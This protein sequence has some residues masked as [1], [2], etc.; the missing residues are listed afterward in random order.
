LIFL[1]IGLICGIS[2]AAPLNLSIVIEND[3]NYTNSIDVDLALS[4]DNTTGSTNCSFSN[5]GTSWP[6]LE[7]YS[8]S[9]VYTLPAGNGDRYVY[10]RCTNDGEN[11]SDTVHAFIILD[12]SAPSIDSLSPANNGVSTDTT[13]VISAILSDSGSGIDSSLTE[14]KVDGSNV[15]AT[16]DS[17]SGKVSYTSPSELSEANHSVEITAYDKV[18]NFTIGSWSFIVD[19]A[20]V[21]ENFYP[22]N[23]DNVKSTSFTVS[24]DISDSGSGINTSR[25]IMKIND[26]TVN[27][28]FPSGKI[29][30]DADFSEGTKEIELWIYDLSGSS[31]Y[32]NWNITIDKSEPT[33]TQMDPADKST[34]SFVNRISARL[35]D[36][37]S[38]I[39]ESSI[40]MKL[41]K[42]DVTSFTSYSGSTLTYSTISGLGGG[43]HEV[44]IWVEDKAGNSVFK[45]WEFTISSK[46]PTID[47]ISPSEGSSTSNKKPVISARFTDQS[48]SGLNLNSPKIYLDGVDYTS[49]AK[50]DNSKRIISYTTTADLTEGEHTAK[51]E[52][53]DNAFA[54]AERSWTFTIDTT[55]PAAPTDLNVSVVG[56]RATLKWTKA[57]DAAKYNIYRSTTKFSSI[58]GKTAT[59]SVTGTTYT[60]SSASGK[61]YYG[62]TA[63]DSTGNE[64]APAYAATCGEYDDGWKDYACCSDTDCGAAKCNITSHTC[65]YPTVNVS[66]SK[67]ENAIDSAKTELDT[68]FDE[69]KNVSSAQDLIDQAQSSFNIGNYAAA[70]DLADKAKLELVSAPL[71][72]ATDSDLTPE[73][74]KKLPCCPSIFIL[75]G[76]LG[77]GFYYRS[78]V[79]STVS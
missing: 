48:T 38:G 67:A 74:K 17:V 29:E 46:D 40:Q 10:Y 44:E 56:S 73:G 77:A 51:V 1:I 35:A 53:S 2:F 26:D 39:K 65:Y 4:A 69:G 71:I 27:V 79:Q 18:G 45:F 58:S 52:V 11:W 61:V 12:T 66:K 19:K 32:K 9:K 54:K 72:N 24:A 70:M 41:D 25:S 16:Y 28:T 57:T 62:I 78:R 8:P 49:S 55:G 59:K 75:L 15:S 3:A 43:K 60:D 14:F 50:Y 37:H 64:G 22:K 6:G 20:P 42:A 36:A 34:K 5:D 31:T 13:P 63:L 76:V 33:V 68:A 23:G 47:M 30:H 21:V 7:A